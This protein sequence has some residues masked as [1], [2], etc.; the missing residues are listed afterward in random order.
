MSEYGA[1]SKNYND[2]LVAV[3]KFNEPNM[4]ECLKKQL[5]K[6]VEVL[7]LTPWQ[8]NKLIKLDIKTIGELLLSTESKLMQA[9]YVGEVKARQ[10]KNAAMAAVF[11]YLFG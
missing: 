7:E 6:S 9:Y 3:P 4:S 8:K 2:L 1:N 5:G 10:M 11:E